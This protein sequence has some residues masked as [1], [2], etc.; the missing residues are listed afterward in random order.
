MNKLLTKILWGKQSKW[1]FATA[2]TGFLLGLLILLVSLQLYLDVKG[3]LEA[4]ARSSADFLI[5][6]KDISLANTFGLSSSTFSEAEIDSLRR[7][8]FVKRL[9]IFTA[10]QF[11]AMAEGNQTVPFYTQIFF[12]SV[13]DAFLDDIPRGWRWNEA[14]KAVPVIVS[15]DFLNL[16]NFGFAPSQGLPQLSRATVQLVPLSLTVSGPRAQQKFPA[17]IAGFSDR[18][19]SVLVPE[20]FMRWANQNIG[21]GRAVPPSRLIVQVNDASDPAIA[22]YL[23]QHGYQTNNDKLKTSQAGRVFQVVTSLVGVVGIFFIGLSFIIFTTH[24]RVIIAE[25][26]EEI[27]LLLQLGYR[28][29]TIARHLLGYFALFLA[30]VMGLVF[31]LLHLAVSR[32]QTFVQAQG[33]ELREG[34]SAVVMLTGMALVLACL[35]VNTWSVRQLL[36]GNQ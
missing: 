6:N 10:S 22:D 14:S 2:G 17:R 18:I 5:L 23:D 21:P 13:P 15:Q 8:P 16:Y 28:V 29:G 34:I 32:A 26:K 12:E 9:G 24:F 35:A 30:L 1:Q 19:S 20:S 25:A 27:S 31:A 33:I 7:Q 3:M 11:Q 4:K 36:K